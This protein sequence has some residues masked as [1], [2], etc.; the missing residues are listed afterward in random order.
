MEIEC[1]KKLYRV[2]GIISIIL[3][4]ISLGFII[5]QSII[6]IIYS[7]KLNKNIITE[8]LIYEQFS[9]EVYS[10]INSH[11]ITKISI[12]SKEATCSD[13][14][15][16]I[17]IP[18]KIEEF[19]DCGKDENIDEFCQNKIT[20][21]SL[22]CHKGCCF[23]KIENKKESKYCLQK[24]ELT[25]NDI[26]KNDDPR[27]KACTK[28]N[29]Y[30]GKFYIVNNKKIC[31]QKNGKTYEEFLSEDK[32]YGYCNNLKLDS[33][34][35][36]YYN[37]ENLD[38]SGI[39]NYENSLIVK[40]I[41]STTNPNYFEMESKL[42]ISMILNRKKY[43]EN[44]IKKEINKISEISSKNIF[45]TFNDEKCTRDGCSNQNYIKIYVDQYSYNLKTDILDKSDEYIF[46]NYK[47]DDYY[48]NKNI[49]WYTRNYI[50][51]QN[52][53]ELN[54]FKD[55]FDVNDHKNNC[56]F[57]IS[58]VLYPNI[59]SI[60]IGII[61]IA[62][63]IILII[64]LF[65][66]NMANEDYKYDYLILLAVFILFLFYFLMYLI[67]YL[68]IFKEI[69]IDMEDFYSN[70]LKKY[71]YRRRQLYL[72]IAV[73]ILIVDLF[74]ELLNLNIK[75]SFKNP[76]YEREIGS[77]YIR[78]EIKI[79]GSSCQTKH[80]IRLYNDKI[81]S[82]YI[83]NINTRIFSRCRNCRNLDFNSFRIE[84]GNEINEN[85]TV[86]ENNIVNENQVI[87]CE[88]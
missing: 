6:N 10:N 18:I 87:I 50:G 34:G 32:N 80:Y 44:K 16:P 33:K 22:C 83:D 40:N 42:R 51:F 55:F 41:F 48:S 31:V 88:E 66:N 86:R 20:P 69:N 27:D 23:E 24:R 13:G 60:I 57:K 29:K 14:S 63:S 72:M 62:L 12:I 26:R 85:K 74:L 81:F 52:I 65:K 49:Y 45:D 64:H 15:D 76:E 73:I 8:R 19:Y 7:F 68:V 25:G 75:Y 77:N 79:E 1:Q 46:K 37:I 3:L 43:N 53:T 9:H 4:I 67:G 56:L 5:T 78:V 84:N 35:H 11:P 54:K 58:K 82:D 61:I 47:N 39:N 30:L 28:F 2:I 17:N 21:E 71:N 59:E 70:I 38:Y 36:C